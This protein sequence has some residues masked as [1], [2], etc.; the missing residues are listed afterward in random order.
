MAISRRRILYGA[1][2]SV[3]AVAGKPVLARPAGPQR[4]RSIAFENLHTGERLNTIYWADGAYQPDALRDVARVL[5][6]HRNNEVHPIDAGL[7]DLLSALTAKLDKT[8]C[9]YKVISGYRSPRTN[10]MLASLSSGVAHHS[11]HTQGMAIDIRVAG[12]GLVGLRDAAKSLRGGGVGFYPRSDFVHV[13]V[14][15]VRYW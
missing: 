9:C 11:L 6:D 1:L 4:P 7:L 13:D 3:M 5:R 12:V 14:G 2:T 8:G 10:A 15:R